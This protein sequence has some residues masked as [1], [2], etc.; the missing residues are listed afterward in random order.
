MPVPKR[1][2]SQAVRP[3]AASLGAEPS[4]HRPHRRSDEAPSSAA[5]PSG[6]ASVPTAAPSVPRASGVREVVGPFERD[7]R[8]FAAII[9]SSED[10]II[11]KNLNSV[12]TTWNPA[13]ERM[14]GYPASEM[15]GRSI[16]LLI[17]DDRQNEEDE[18]LSRV[19]R[20]E[21]VEHYE[22]LRRCQNGALLPV[23]LT[24]SPIRNREGAVVGVSTIARDISDHKRAEKEHQRLQ[25]MADEANRLKDEFLTT[26]SHEMRTPL[27]AI[28]GYVRMIQSGLL[29]GDKQISAM[30]AIARNMKSL[31]QIVEDVLDVSSILSGKVRLELRAVDILGIVEAA[32]EAIRPA[33]EGKGITLETTLDPSAGLVFGDAERLRQILWNVLSNA[34]KFTGREGRVHVRLAR[35]DDHIEVSVRD[36]GVGILSAFLPHVFE[37]FRQGDAGIERVHGGLGLGLAITRHLVELQGGRILGTSDGP[38]A[39]STFRIELPRWAAP[40]ALPTAERDAQTAPRAVDMPIT[41]AHLEGIHV[42]AVDDDGDAL[43][44]VREI[45]EATGATVTTAES[46]PQA[47]EVLEGTTPDVL[48][49]D[50]SMPHMSGLALINRVR[51][52]ERRELREIPAAALTAY[53]RADDRTTAL[54]SGFQMHLAKPIDPGELMAAVAVLA[55][56]A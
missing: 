43:A 24:V 19:R 38:G 40:A 5:S 49:A 56:R 4:S 30:N 13:A 2:S 47:L 26:L 21:R 35:V 34:L 22:T 33:A 20:G 48:L 53:A 54:G 8:H 32:V 9:E 12:V 1:V 18:V 50:L 46:A 23:L 7:A 41:V 37:R 14:F 39:G 6:N 42:L 17:P 29:V 15:I 10:A 51:R 16:R 52:S 11:S 3:A 31:G 36:T 28:V 27:N 55:K 45:L 44:L 25:A